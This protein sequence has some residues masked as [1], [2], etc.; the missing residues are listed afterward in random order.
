[1]SDRVRGPS[2]HPQS[3]EA[4]C[5]G[6]LGIGESCG[7]CRGTGEGRRESFPEMEEQ[8]RSPARMGESKADYGGERGSGSG[9]QKE[10]R[11][12]RVEKGSPCPRSQLPACYYHHSISICRKA[13]PIK[14]T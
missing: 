1:M 3:S 7:D 2:E 11:K 14:H 5:L 13:T 9:V 4:S 10:R 12:R 8:G 6:L